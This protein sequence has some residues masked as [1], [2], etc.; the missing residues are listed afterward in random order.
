MSLGVGHHFQLTHFPA[1][2]RNLPKTV[3]ASL[4]LLGSVGSLGFA[5]SLFFVIILYTPPVERHATSPLHDSLSAPH[6]EFYY[7]PLALF[8]LTLGFL[9][10]ALRN[11]NSLSPLRSVYLLAPFFFAFL[12]EVCISILTS[13]DRHF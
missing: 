7:Y 8:L 9:P 13:R 1:Q 12:P 5:Q 11:G 10:G 4:V 2:K 6:R 3:I